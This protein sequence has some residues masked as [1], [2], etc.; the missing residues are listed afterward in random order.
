MESSRVG[1][2]SYCLNPLSLSACEILEWT[3]ARGGEGVQF[4]E[5]NQA[6]EDTADP[7]F[8][9]E[10]AD[11]RRDLN[12]YV[13]WG[14][15]QHVPF[16]TTTW[17]ERDLLD[18]N[19]RAAEAASAV[20]ARVIRSCSGGFFRWEDTAPDTDTL[21][22]AMAA[23]LQ[24][25]RA[26]FDDLGVTLAIELH[27]EFTTFELLRLFEMC[28]AEPGGWLG[29]CLDTFN[30]LPMLEDPVAGTKRILP[31]VAATHIK[32][33]AVVLRPYGI[34]TF[35]TPLG[36]GHVD[37]PAILDLLDSVNQ[38]VNLSIE[39]H[40]GSFS[41]AIFDAAFIE[42]FPDLTGAEMDNLLR[43]GREGRELFA[44]GDLRITERAN[45]PEICEQRTASDLRYLKDLVSERS[46]DP[47]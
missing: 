4:S 23:A 39:G 20:G 45:W 35:P 37:L 42:R 41:T 34:T 47:H 38:P 29:I 40:G 14:G 26:L 28:D 44:N 21:V 16:N 32:D 6:A 30:M 19:R 12:L 7:V 9:R 13:E 33:G 24:P 17:E 8:L 22:T 5:G 11:T 43:M 27:F 10:V 18:G 3:A 15:G 46:A 25:Q 36:G 1:I 2:D 31:W